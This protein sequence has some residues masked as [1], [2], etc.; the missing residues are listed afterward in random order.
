[1]QAQ[2]VKE[3]GENIFPSLRVIRSA[4]KPM[5]EN[6]VI[7]GDITKSGI[8]ARLS[9]AVGGDKLDFINPSERSE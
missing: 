9:M 6:G 8:F 3:K 4:S 2:G 5:I 7:Q 1:M